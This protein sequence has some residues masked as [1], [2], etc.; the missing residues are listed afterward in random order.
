MTENDGRRWDFL[1]AWMESIIEVTGTPRAIAKRDIT[2]AIIRDLYASMGVNVYD[3]ATVHTAIVTASMIIELSS[4]V[5]QGGVFTDAE[6][7]TVCTAVG[8][9][10]GGLVDY[11]PDEARVATQYRS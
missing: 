1:G 11:M 10:L 3:A 9:F 7:M 6:H 2:G 4:R 8:A 5:T